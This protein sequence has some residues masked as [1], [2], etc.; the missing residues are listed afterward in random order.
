MQ[1]SILE[2]AIVAE[3]GADNMERVGQVSGTA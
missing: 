3:Y 2:Q 1:D